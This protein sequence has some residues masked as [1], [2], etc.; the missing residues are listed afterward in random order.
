MIAKVL[1]I[2]AGTAVA[3]N[4]YTLVSLSILAASFEPEC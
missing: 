1:A 4:G 2:V 3:V